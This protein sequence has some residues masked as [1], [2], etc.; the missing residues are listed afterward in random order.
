MNNSIGYKSLFE[1][2]DIHKFT[3][4]IL[5]KKDQPIIDDVLISKKIKQ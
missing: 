3:K 1:N 2:K 4:K 5:S